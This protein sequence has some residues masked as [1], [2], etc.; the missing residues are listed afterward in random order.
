[1][2]MDSPLPDSLWGTRSRGVPSRCTPVATRS[3]QVGARAARARLADRTSTRQGRLH[4]GR[5]GELPHL[6]SE[7]SAPIALIVAV[8][9]SD[10]ANEFVER[11]TRP[12]RTNHNRPIVDGHLDGIALIELRLAHH[13]FWKPD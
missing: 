11:V 2:R 9:R 4:Q 5:N 3:V 13:C 7:R 8:P 1:P 12:T 6:V 10:T